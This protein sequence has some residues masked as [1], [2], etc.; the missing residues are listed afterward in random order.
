MKKQFVP[1]YGCG[2]PPQR[3]YLLDKDAGGHT[4]GSLPEAEFQTKVLGNV[5][6]VSDTVTALDGRLKAIETEGGAIRSDVDALKR[7]NSTVTSTRRPGE[8]SE[9]AARH[10]AARCILQG[11]NLDN[12][13]GVFKAMDARARDTITGAAREVLGITGKTA[14]TSSDIPLPVNYSGDVVELVSEWGAA[15]RYGTVFPL[16]T[17]TVKLPKLATDPTFALIAA[18]GSV[19]EKV[20][21]TSWVTFTAEKFGGIVRVPS[22]IDAD[23]IVPLGQF[24]ARYAARQLAYVEDYQFFR[25]SGAGSGLNGSVEGLCISTITNS[26]VT[27]MASSKVKYSDATLA[28]FRTLRS[29][30][31]AAALG[32]SAYYMHPSFEQHLAGLNT[33]GDRPYIAMGVQG[34]SLDG[35][36]IRWVDAMP[37]YSTSSNASKVFALFGDLS[38]QYLGVR[39]GVSLD[40]SKE[41]YFATDELGIRALERLTIGLMA[42]GAVAGLETAAS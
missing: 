4:G 36:P 13:G 37:A 35:F 30:V 14:I 7:R 18:S 22:E 40:V 10:I 29:V 31:D 1:F 15:R 17:G 9:A 24:I 6:S 34:A 19:S 39:Q 12:D 27:Q 21:Q 32:R 42:T 11:I 3:N 33:A 23:S 5:K 8:V 20:P 25:S 2:R 41:V 38:F 28:N 16:G 26:K